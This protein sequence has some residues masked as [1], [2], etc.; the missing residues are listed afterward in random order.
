MP[1]STAYNIETKNGQ[2]LSGLLAT[3]TTASVV[4]RRAFGV[5][6]LIPCSTIASISTSRFSR[7]PRELERTIWKQPLADLVRFM[8]GGAAK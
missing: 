8:K 4:L 5:K 3:E 6:Q 2:S 7:M 1:I